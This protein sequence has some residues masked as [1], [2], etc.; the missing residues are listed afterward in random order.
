[1]SEKEF[2]DALSAKIGGD[3][4][5]A[6]HFLSCVSDIISSGLQDGKDV[7]LLGFGIFEVKKKM[8]RIEVNSSTGKRVLFPPK[9]VVGFRPSSMLKE[10]I[11][12]A[13]NS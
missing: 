11:N 9:L 12:S 7:S 10:R 8:E 2:I 5:S 13:L 3:E 4:K 6:S 1:M